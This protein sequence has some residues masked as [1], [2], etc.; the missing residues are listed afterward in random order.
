METNKKILGKINTE[1]CS[2]T[3]RILPREHHQINPNQLIG[4]IMVRMQAEG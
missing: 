3:L 2:V 4:N 1:R